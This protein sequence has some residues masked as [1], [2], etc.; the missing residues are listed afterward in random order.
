MYKRVTVK[1]GSNVVAEGQGMLNVARMAAIVNQIANLRKRGIEIVLVSSG[2]VAAGKA[3]IELPDKTDSVSQRQVW[4]SVGQIH[5]INTY[6]SLFESQGLVCAQ[7]LVTKDDFRDR[8]HYLNLQNCL[9]T[10]LATDVVPIINEND[11][12]S[13]TELMFTD[14]DELSGLIASLTDSDALVILSNIDG[15]FD[16]NPQAPESAVISEIE[17]DN[18]KM[19]DIIQPSKSFFGR[20]G[21]ESKFKV[22][23]KASQ[24]GINVIIANGMTPTILEDVISDTTN[25]LCT[26]FVPKE[27][28]SQVKKW[29]SHSHGFAKGAIYVN[30]G[31]KEVLMSDKA[32]SVLAVGIIKSDGLFNKGDII[33]IKDKDGINIGIGRTSFDAKKVAKIMGLHGEKPVIH[34]NY[35]HID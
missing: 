22:A 4:S 19:E 33:R 3:V 32:I 30:D 20:G 24:N 27:K 15:V 29:I 26:H 6:A 17:S 8:T 10:L 31:A 16:G 11:A 13:I 2:A 18:V 25:T 7:L 5:L 14:N 12:I 34:Y 9:T 21:M 23:K 35:L 28:S 1:I